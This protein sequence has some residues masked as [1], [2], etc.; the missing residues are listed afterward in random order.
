MAMIPTEM[1]VADEPQSTF[2]IIRQPSLTWRI[3]F[4][5]NRV[6]GLCDELKAYEQAVYLALNVERYKYLILSWNYGV[7][8][9]GLIGQPLP[10]VVPELERVITEAVMQD[11]RTQSVHS[12][13]FDTSQR[14]IVSLRFVAQSIYG[15]VTI[16]KDLVL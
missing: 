5:K 16:Q 15:E 10:Y 11:D 7:E 14:G 6:V 1:N 8:L 4:T 9:N 13:E 3:D 2:E 12:F